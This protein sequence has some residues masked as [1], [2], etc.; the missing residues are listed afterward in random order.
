MRGPD[1]ASDDSMLLTPAHFLDIGGF[2]KFLLTLLK[3]SFCEEVF[4]LGAADDVE[5]NDGLAA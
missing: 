4:L 2:P 3:I 5:G 1:G